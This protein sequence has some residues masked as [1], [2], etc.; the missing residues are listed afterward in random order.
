MPGLTVLNVNP[1]VLAE[2][3]LPLGA[4]GVVVENP[5]PYGA[6]FGMRPGDV[7]LSIN[8][9]PITRT[10]QVRDALREAL[11]AR[12]LRMDLQRG[13]QRLSLRSRL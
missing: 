10:A 6:R 4:E 1:A 5:G 13:L 8:G 11:Q 2:F 9:E 12:A 3:N 7:I